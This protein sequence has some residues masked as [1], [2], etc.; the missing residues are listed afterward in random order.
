MLSPFKSITKKL[1]QFLTYMCC[2]QETQT[3]PV[4]T[5]PPPY[6]KK[7]LVFM[8]RSNAYVS[9]LLLAS[10]TILFSCKKTDLPADYEQVVEKKKA[11]CEIASFRYNTATENGT[12]TKYVF[13]K[14]NDPATGKLKQV[15]AAVYQGGAIMNTVV[16]DVH[17]NAGSVAF[18]R[19]GTTTDTVLFASLNAQGKP[20]DVV[21]GNTPDFNYLPTSFEYNNNRLA[22]MKIQNAG[23]VLV[24]RYQYDGRNNCIS[25]IDDALASEIPGHVEYAYDSRKVDQQVYLDEPRPFSWNTFSLMQFSGFFP[26]LQPA[27]LRSGVKVFWANN[28]KA[29]DVQLVNHQI[30]DGK[31]TQYEVSFGGT[32]TPT[33]R[34]IDWQ[35]SDDA[36]KN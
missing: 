6:L 10:S 25:I 19:A 24:S 20:A 30:V 18:L 9:G 23:Q 4:K 2:G 35:C 29:Y 21:V 5:L 14:Q 12:E 28:Y 1:A 8:K 3:Q 31:L 34:F 7:N 15:I 36:S 17:W 13:Q 33:A 26:E 22:A 32:S 16:F 27:T 11:T